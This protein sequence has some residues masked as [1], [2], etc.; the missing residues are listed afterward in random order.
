MK[1]ILTY[2]LVL[3]LVLLVSCAL[4]ALILWGTRN[5]L[6]FLRWAML[7]AVG[8]LLVQAGLLCFH[9]SGSIFQDSGG[10]ISLDSLVAAILI[11]LSVLILAGWGL[12]WPACSRWEKRKKQKN[13]GNS[14]P[15]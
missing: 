11:L 14:P 12:A 6:R 10:F 5:R 13:D 15:S 8:F 9:P 3:A 7:P 1:L 2:L 4:Q